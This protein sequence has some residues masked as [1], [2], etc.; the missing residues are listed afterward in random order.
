MKMK[1]AGLCGVMAPPIVFSLILAAI[2]QSPWFSWTKNALSDLGVQGV[3]ATL[4]NSSLILGGLLALVFAVG[5]RENLKNQLLG[6]IGSL[7]FILDAAA[8]SAIGVFPETVGALHFY[9]SVTF[10]VLLPL[11]LLFIGGAMIDKGRNRSLGLLSIL[12][13]VVAVAVWA[14]PRRGVAIP[15]ALSGLSASTW[16]MILGFKLFRQETLFQP[17]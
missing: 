4:F 7:L 13:G 1:M 11:S 16:S 17:N 10:F 9:V 15:E 12:A 8:L 3:V 5:L 2:S 14:L 6:Q